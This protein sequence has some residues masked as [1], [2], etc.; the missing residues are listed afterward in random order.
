MN[1]HPK[2]SPSFPPVL[3]P[4]VICRAAGERKVGVG[5]SGEFPLALVTFVLLQFLQTARFLS[6]LKSG[7]LFFSTSITLIILVLTI[8]LL[9]MVVPDTLPSFAT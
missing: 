9:F 6:I 4:K 5:S 7:V 8:L 2:V 1:F 3:S